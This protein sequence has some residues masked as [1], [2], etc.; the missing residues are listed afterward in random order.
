MTTM[1]RRPNIARRKKL[2]GAA[3]ELF[4]KKG[5][6]ETTYQDIA[7]AIGTT[8]TIVQSYFP[9]KTRITE[10]IFNDLM[11]AAYHSVGRIGLDSDSPLLTL[12]RACHVF[13]AYLLHDEEMR[14]FAMTTLSVRDGTTKNIITDIEWIKDFCGDIFEDE[15]LLAVAYT[16]S[17]GGAYEIIYRCLCNDLPIHVGS[18]AALTIRLF[19]AVVGQPDLEEEEL[20]TPIP[21]DQLEKCYSYIDRNLFK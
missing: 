5:Y 21:D 14:H 12:S 11:G 13:L 10:E 8:R 16:M 6:E 4:K 15:E 1:T 7:D 19:L 2:L 18:L 9:K 3:F 20:L 17:L